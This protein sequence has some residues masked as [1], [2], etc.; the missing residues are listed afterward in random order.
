MALPKVVVVG[1]P[2]VGRVPLSTG[3]PVPHPPPLPLRPAAHPRAA[4][5]HP[6]H[7]AWAGALGGRPHT[8][9][10][11][12]THPPARAERMTAADRPGPPRAPGHGRFEPDGLPFVAIDPAGV[13]ARRR[14]ATA[15]TSTR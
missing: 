13:P 9:K 8:G 15:S 1:R 5:A 3:L 12:F 7:P 14:S 10:R 2:N 4:P 6:A 11:A